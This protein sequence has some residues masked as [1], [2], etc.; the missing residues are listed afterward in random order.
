MSDPTRI[1]GTDPSGLDKTVRVN[2]KRDLMSGTYGKYYDAVKLGDVFSV[3]TPDEGVAPG[4]DQSSTTAGFSIFNPGASGKDVVI[5]NARLAYVSGTLGAGEIY[6][7][8][9]TNPAAAVPTGTAQS[10][11][12]CYLGGG[13]ASVARPLTTVTLPAAATRV[14]VF[15]ALD[16]SLATTAGIG[17]RVLE[18]QVDGAIIVSPGTT[19]SIMADAAAGTTPLVAISV[20]YAEVEV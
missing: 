18:D 13:R 5:L 16:A 3:T 14:R 17:E 15:G 19:I 6:W 10:P 9:N 2:A 8:A 20:T 7:M 4:T 1:Q 12:N 11:V